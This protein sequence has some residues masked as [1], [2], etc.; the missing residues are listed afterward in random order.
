MQVAASTP[1]SS[2]DAFRLYC[3]PDII[4]AMKLIWIRTGNGS[5]QA[6]AAFNV[7]G[8]AA[9]GK[10]RIW[11]VPFTNQSGYMDLVLPAGTFA[12]FHVHPNNS[13]GMPSTKDNNRRGNGVGDTGT[14]NRA[15]IRIYIVSR[16]G[17]AFYDGIT[18]QPAVKLRNGLDWTHPC[19]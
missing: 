11:P 7:T 19:K 6:E 8:V 16:E 14:A 12:N 15:G 13:G 3:Q 17:L 5:S 18:R 4:E 1:T 10:Y 9:P 2:P